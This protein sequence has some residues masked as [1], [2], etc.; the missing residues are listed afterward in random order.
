MRLKLYDNDNPHEEP[1]QIIAEN[2]LIAIFPLL[3]V[4]NHETIR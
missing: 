4:E 1:H 2:D 3:K